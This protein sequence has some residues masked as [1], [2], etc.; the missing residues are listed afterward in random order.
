MKKIGF[1]KKLYIGSLS[2]VLLTILI[3]AVVNFYQSKHS[4]LAKGQI[5]IKS[6]SDVLFETVELKYTLQREKIDSDMGALIAESQSAGKTM[7]VKGRTLD[8]ETRDI[9]SGNRGQLTLPKLIFGL[10]FITGSHTIVD[11]VG[12]N[13]RSEISIYQLYDNK[14]I[15]VSTN[16][17]NEDDSRPIG[18]YYPAGS[19]VYKKLMEG[20]PFL[21]L[22]RGK[23]GVVM[24]LVHPFKQAIDGAIIGAYSVSSSVITKRLVNLVNKVNVGGKGYSFVSGA[25]GRILSHPDKSYLSL[26]VRDFENGKELLQKGSNFV[27]YGHD[28][29]TYYS[30]VNYFKPW[31]LYFTVSISEEELMAGVNRQIL[32]SVGISGA[33]AL[34]VGV[35][36]IFFMNRQLMKSMNGMAT[37]AREVA[38]G[39]FQYTFTYEAK[40][41]IKD[42]VDSMNDMVQ[43]LAGMIRELSSGVG[44]LNSASGEINQI[45]DKMSQGSE[46]TVSKV[47]TVA[48]AAEEMSANMDSVA[49]AM[50]QASTNV[51]TVSTGTGEMSTSIEKVV[52]NSNHTREITSQAVDQAQKTSVRVGELG[53]AAEEI[54]KVTDTITDISSQTN[55]LALNATIE[56]ARAG[57]AGKGF[58][59]VANEIKALAGQTAGATEDIAKNIQKIQDQIKGAVGEISEISKIITQIDEFVNEAASAIEQQSS[60]TSQIADNISQVSTGIQ[61]VNVNVTQTSDASG[62]VA[63]E[64]H[65]VLTASQEINDL[66]SSVKQKAEIVDQVMHQLQDMT[67]KFTI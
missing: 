55:L 39:N 9:T 64:I 35:L 36:I 5:S 19:E 12:G 29:R 31:N 3:I 46:T 18:D 58:G 56:A 26:D 33:L 44:T 54:N 14:L 61:E 21:T 1:D 67:E 42:T 50:E 13:T 37:L 41:A 27:T 63:H 32:T 53:K 60:T 38:G 7:V 52:R 57:E 11:K 47:N 24:Q 43:D 2:I 23:T 40:D 6:V 10:E 4:F 30:H 25:D 15:K 66:A 28:N 8:L 49:A 34:I 51:E 65:D 22:A 59:V 16:D 45:S 62:Q 20:Q 17:R 48:S